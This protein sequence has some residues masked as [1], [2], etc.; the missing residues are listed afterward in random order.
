MQGG[1]HLTRDEAQ[2]LRE[3]AADD[4]NLEVTIYPGAS[5]MS[6]LYGRVYNVTTGASVQGSDFYR[7]I[8]DAKLR[9]LPR[10]RISRG[11]DVNVT[12]PTHAIQEGSTDAERTPNTTTLWAAL[13]GYMAWAMAHG[14]A[15]YGALQRQVSATVQRLRAHR[16]EASAT[17]ASHYAASRHAG[18]RL[19]RHHHFARHIGV[20]G[21]DTFAARRNASMNHHAPA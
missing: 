2:R 20:I 6:V 16:S 7:L 21:W 14:K 19:P 4:P 1:N 5:D 13:T 10:T 8:H 15:A 3:S 9:L 17:P 18:R 11:V 12:Q